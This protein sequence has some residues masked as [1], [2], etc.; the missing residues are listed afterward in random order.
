M[1]QGPL[2][3]GTSDLGIDAHGLSPQFRAGMTMDGVPRTLEDDMAAN[4]TVS[5]ALPPRGRE[6]AVLRVAAEYNP[7]VLRIV[8]S[9][10]MP[11]FRQ[12]LALHRYLLHRD[13]KL[14]R[15]ADAAALA[16]TMVGPRTR[17]ET[18]LI[19]GRLSDHLASGVVAAQVVVVP[20][21]SSLGAPVQRRETHDGRTIV[22]VAERNAVMSR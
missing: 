13:R 2:P 1:A 4:L 10:P 14:Q 5:T 19:R 18:D 3:P 6:A 8:A 21:R 12:P 11:D 16:R 7:H 20:S 9:I 17:I 15:L 22:T